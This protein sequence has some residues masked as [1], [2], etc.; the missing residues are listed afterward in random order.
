MGQKLSLEVTMTD[1][2]GIDILIGI[3]VVREAEADQESADE[4]DNM[5]KLAR[6]NPNRIRFSYESHGNMNTTM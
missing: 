5:G 2:G 4:G 3:G 1:I 6:W